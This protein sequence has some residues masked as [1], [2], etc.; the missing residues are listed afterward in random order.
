VFNKEANPQSPTSKTET[1]LC[2]WWELARK[3][4]ATILRHKMTRAPV[5]RDRELMI[6]SYANEV[7][8][9]PAFD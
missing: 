1:F 5:I 9:L 2:N 3:R 7:S 4:Y 6:S 8:A